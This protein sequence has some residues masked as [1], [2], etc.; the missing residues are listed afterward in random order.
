MHSAIEALERR[1]F[2]T[3]LND[4]FR[5]LRENSKVW[6]A[7]VAERKASDALA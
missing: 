5:L 1:E 7:Y 2:Q 4:D 3:G 6:A